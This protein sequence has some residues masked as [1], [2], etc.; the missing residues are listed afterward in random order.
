MQRSTAEEPV[1]GGSMHDIGA[2]KNACLDAHASIDAILLSDL[3]HSPCRAS[4]CASGVPRAP[5]PH[6]PSY[7][8]VTYPRY[9]PELSP[10]IR[11]LL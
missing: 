7:H 5:R 4:C 10:F 9:S 6:I 2:V 1:C 8:A 3:Y 11:I